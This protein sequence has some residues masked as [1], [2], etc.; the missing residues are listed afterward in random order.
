MVFLQGIKI[1]ICP[2]KQNKIFALRS[3]S[4]SRFLL[5]DVYVNLF[6]TYISIRVPERKQ[7][8]KSPFSS[9]SSVAQLCPTLQPRK[10]QLAR[11][12]C[13]SPTP[14]VYSNSCPL[15][16]RCHP[17]ISSSVVPFSFCPQ[18]LPAS[19]SFPYN[20]KIKWKC[21]LFL[22]EINVEQGVNIKFPLQK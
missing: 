10:S 3:F 17:A 6:T 2:N 16:R 5:W 7:T 20:K 11:S 15:I 8:C 12:P 21:L 1:R 4:L 19:G 22:R 13:P 14:G 18:S 9:V